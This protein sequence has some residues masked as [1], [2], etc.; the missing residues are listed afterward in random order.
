[1]TTA[2]PVSGLGLAGRRLLLLISWADDGNWRFLNMLR[3]HGATVDLLEPLLQRSSRAP[4]WLKRLCASHSMFYQCVIAL[5]R[6]RRYDAVATWNTSSGTL[7]GALSRLLPRRLRPRHMIRDFHLDLT[8]FADP[9][10]LP[11]VLLVRLAAPVV[12]VLLTTSTEEVDLYRRMFDLPAS[13]VHF[14]PDTAGGA[15]MDAEPTP[16]GGSDTIFAYGNSDRDFDTLL[17]AAP[18][19]PGRVVIL[20]QNYTPSVPV[21]ANVTCIGHR[22]PLD[23]LMTMIAQAAVVVIPIKS[24]FVAAG[25][26][27]MLEVMSLS[28]PMVVTTGLATV[29]HAVDGREAVFCPAQDPAALAD[30]VTGLLARPEEARRMGEAARKAALAFPERQVAIFATVL[31]QLLDRDAST[32]QPQPEA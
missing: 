32:G 15:Y 21:P 10:Y 12:D 26:N 29:D 20:S 1:M 30:A 5:L 24:R 14:F 8:R 11:R 25:Q 19:I 22:V 31:Q 4:G 16:C 28:R 2:T 6:G 23:E 17:E 7:L 9:F 3:Q 13:R 27:A 18:R